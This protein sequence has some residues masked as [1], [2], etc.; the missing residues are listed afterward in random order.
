MKRSGICGR[1]CLKMWLVAFLF[2]VSAAVHAAF[3]NG[4]SSSVEQTNDKDKIGLIYKPLTAIDEETVTLKG[5]DKFELYAGSISSIWGY[6]GKVAVGLVR[7]GNQLVDVLAEQAVN[8]KSE[9]VVPQIQFVCRVKEDTEVL[10]GDE[11]RLLVT[12]DGVNYEKLAGRPGVTDAIPAVKYDLPLLKIT[13]PVDVP[14]VEV[15]LGETALWPDKVI[16][17]TNFFF[18]VDNLKPETTVAAVTADGSVLFPDKYG[19]YGISNVKEEHVIEIK[20]YD[21]TAVDPYKIIDCGGGK[22]VADL[23]TDEEMACLKGLK[24]KGNLKAE[25]FEVFRGRMHSLEILD[26]LDTKLENNWLPLE[27]FA[28]NQTIKEVKLPEGV[29]GSDNNA[30]YYAQALEFIVLPENLTQFGLNMFFGCESL[31]KV[32]VK[33]NP[34]EKGESMGFPIPPCA[35]RATSYM[36]DGLLIVPKG[37]KNIYSMSNIWGSFHTIREEAPLDRIQMEKPFESYLDVAGTRVDASEVAVEVVEGGCRIVAQ[38]P[39]EVAVFD[40]SGCLVHRLSVGAGETVLPL[41]KG[42]FFVQTGNLSHKV[43]VR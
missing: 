32:W 10:E 24:V 34:A 17:G 18:Y 11:I 9:E 35:F 13:M 8:W 40:M 26:L 29:Q 12:Q 1:M 38:T 4:T 43:A 37:C 14:G 20:V 28:Y 31:K 2:G 30:F 15:R 21:R 5:G 16:K 6:K 39:M 36:T 42:I 22:R 33:Y 25:D 23:L 3:I 19:M 27:A 41:P 7:G